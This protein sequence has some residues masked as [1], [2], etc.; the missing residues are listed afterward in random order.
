MSDKYYAILCKN[1]QGVQHRI[2]KRRVDPRTRTIKHSGKYSKD[3]RNDLPVN[4]TIPSIRA[5]SP[6]IGDAY[7]YY[8]DIDTGETL[9]FSK[10]KFPIS[11]ELY[12]ATFGQEVA[13]QLVSGLKERSTVSG[14]LII[15]IIVLSLCCFCVILFIIGGVYVKF[16][17]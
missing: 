8:I 16:K 7:Y 9:T 12:N 6:G 2:G 5:P 10:V 17:C 1:I 13:R 11:K 14:E 15:Y 4:M 3:G